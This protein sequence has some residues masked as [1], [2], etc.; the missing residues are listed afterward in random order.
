[1]S[2]TVMR[3]Y[4][5]TANAAISNFKSSGTYNVVSN[6]E[7][8]LSAIKAAAANPG[9]KSISDFELLDSFVKAAKGGTGK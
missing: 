4:S 5:L 6:V 1:M 2:P 9:D 8:Y 3:K 7:P